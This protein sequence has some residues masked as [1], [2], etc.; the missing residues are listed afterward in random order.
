VTVCLNGCCSDES[1][2]VFVGAVGIPDPEQYRFYTYPVPNDGR[3]TASIEWPADEHF[4]IAVFNTLGSQIYETKVFVFQGRADK[5]IDLR[6]V[7]SGVYSVVFFN[8]EHRVIRRILVN[9]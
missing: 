3:F 5:T 8:S 4:T 2:H 7:P 9:K 6:P 1:E